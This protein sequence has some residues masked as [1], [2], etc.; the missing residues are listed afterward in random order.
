MIQNQVC[1]LSYTTGCMYLFW[2]TGGEFSRDLVEKKD[3]SVS[4][5]LV[6]V[7]TIEDR[8]LRCMSKVISET[9]VS[10]KRCL[11]LTETKSVPS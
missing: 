2:V 8:N 6:K 9:S 7:R 1:C 5:T 4:A 3:T 10:M 11:S